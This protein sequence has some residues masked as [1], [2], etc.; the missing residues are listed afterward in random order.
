MLVQNFPEQ[1][2]L[3]FE[4]VAQSLFESNGTTK[5]LI[6]AVELWLAQNRKRLIHAEAAEN[7]QVFES[8]E[9]EFVQKHHG[10]WIAIAQ[11]KVQGVSDTPEE[12]NHVAESAYHRII[13]ELGQPRTEKVDLGWQMTFA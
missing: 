2:Q 7:N 8:L 13:V 5:A 9:P 3:E 4:Q 12:L 11:G 1:L 6:E 10:K